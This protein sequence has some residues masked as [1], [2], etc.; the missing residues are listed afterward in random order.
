MVT[1]VSEAL[2]HAVT[3]SPT[4]LWSAQFHPGWI[5]TTF[6]ACAAASTRTTSSR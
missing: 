4:R 2:T 6:V 5:S 3:E 1:P